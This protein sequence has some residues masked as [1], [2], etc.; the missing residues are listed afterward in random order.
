[1]KGS[2]IAERVE[3]IINGSSSLLQDG[4]EQWRNGFGPFRP[5]RVVTVGSVVLPP[6]GRIDQR[7][8]PLDDVVVVRMEVP[9]DIEPGRAD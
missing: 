3:P 5:A 4:I 7:P 9:E 1:M 2:G 8:V 6:A